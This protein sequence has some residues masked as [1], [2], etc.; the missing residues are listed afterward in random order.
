MVETQREGRDIHSVFRQKISVYDSDLSGVKVSKRGILLEELSAT[1]RKKHWREQCGADVDQNEY[2]IGFKEYLDSFSYGPND[3]SYTESTIAH[4]YREIRPWFNS[5]AEIDRVVECV[6]VNVERFES[7]RSLL[8][9]G[10]ELNAARRFLEYY[11]KEVA[12]A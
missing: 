11:E 2:L 3:E 1:G 6:K 12:P 10:N 5:D 9:N 8:R 7:D 4:Y